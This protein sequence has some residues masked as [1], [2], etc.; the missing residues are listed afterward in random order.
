TMNSF[1]EEVKLEENPLLIF[2]DG[3]HTYSAVVNDIMA[4]YQLNRRPYAAAFH[5]F[6]LRTRNPSHGNIKVDQAIFDCF[7]LSVD[8]IRI[9]V[10]YGECP[11]LSSHNPSEEGFYHESNGSEGVIVEIYRKELKGKII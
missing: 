1:V 8:Y 3:N 2:V 11:K 4:I 6:S 10:Q 5:D 9:G 7:G